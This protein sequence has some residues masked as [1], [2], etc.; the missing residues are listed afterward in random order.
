MKPFN[1]AISIVLLIAG[2]RHSPKQDNTGKELT[3]TG[4]YCSAFDSV[5]LNGRTL[6]VS[7]PTKR[8]SDQIN[9]ILKR[10]SLPQ[11]FTVYQGNVNNAI[12]LYQNNR[13]YIILNSQFLNEVDRKSSD[14]W[15]SMYLISHEI[16]H[17]LSSHLLYQNVSDSVS[18]AQELQADYFAGATLSRLGCPRDKAKLIFN[19][20]TL[21]G[22]HGS[23][24][25]PPSAIRM[26]FIE[27]GWE[28]NL[29][30]I[31]TESNP[32]PPYN[33][34]DIDPDNPDFTLT[35][36]ELNPRSV[37]GSWFGYLPNSEYNTSIAECVILDVVSLE[38][39]DIAGSAYDDYKH[40]N[41]QSDT[42]QNMMDIYPTLHAYATIKVRKWI[43]TYSDFNTDVSI[44]RVHF[45][46]FAIDPGTHP[47]DRYLDLFAFAY[48]KKKLEI[49]QDHF[50]VGQPI[51]CK[52][53]EEGDFII[54]ENDRKLKTFIFKEIKFLRE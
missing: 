52:I 24:T 25:H 2:C 30:S 33:I 43:K 17:L 34:D 6:Q 51:R 36:K 37:D 53:M 10:I 50:V 7:L 47:T 48:N 11:N 46:D 9:T 16:G 31:Y 4:R 38:Q 35:A 28:N 15:L 22:S 27:D 39:D 5:S 13:N 19:G 12:A 32:P 41:A 3:I 8:Q 54:E 23:H 20:T 29:R 14:Y 44:I 42:I 1:L 49:Y 18:K 40:T 26:N 21:Q 45:R